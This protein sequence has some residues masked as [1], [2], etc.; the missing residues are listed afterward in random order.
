MLKKNS[1]KMKYENA[2]FI[3]SDEKIDM[4]QNQSQ[5][6]ERIIT[7]IICYDDIEEGQYITKIPECKHEMHK[8]CLENWLYIKTNCPICRTKIDLK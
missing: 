7:C 2:E 5:N 8:S 4:N 3:Q 6:L 1:R